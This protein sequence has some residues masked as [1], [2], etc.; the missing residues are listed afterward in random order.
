M[1]VF[2]C[3]VKHSW[4]FTCFFC[5][6]QKL[7][8]QDN[9]PVATMSTDECSSS[10]KVPNFLN[11]HVHA[12]PYG[13]FYTVLA[14]NHKIF[15]FKNTQHQIQWIATPLLLQAS[16]PDIFLEGLLSKYTLPWTI[17]VSWLGSSHQKD[18]TWKK[19]LTLSLS[20][21]FS[22]FPVSSYIPTQWTII[23]NL[24]SSSLKKTWSSLC[25]T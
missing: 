5:G 25:I 4:C 9:F 13:V 12:V 2:F 24:K 7:K 22:L 20:F 23:W 14:T 11:H 21:L 16:Y 15:F 19:S 3:V 6:A 1:V 18:K 10:S 8:Y 17:S